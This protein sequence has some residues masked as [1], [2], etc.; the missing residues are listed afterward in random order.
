M[1][2]NYLKIFEKNKFTM[3]VTQCT[4]KDIFHKVPV[5]RF[6]GAERISR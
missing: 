1:I 3:K 6:T 2:D 5:N 4:E